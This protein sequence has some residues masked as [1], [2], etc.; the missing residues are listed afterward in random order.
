M[1]GKI[2][3]E[4]ENYFVGDVSQTFQWESIEPLHTGN[5]DDFS[6][7]A[8]PPAITKLLKSDS[9]SGPVE[10]YATV[11]KINDHYQAQKRIIVVTQKYFYNIKLTFFRSYSVKRAIGI[12]CIQGLIRNPHRKE[13]VVKVNS[14][15]P[16]DYRYEGD[17]WEVLTAVLLRLCPTISVWTLSSS[18]DSFVKR[19]S[20]ITASR[21][22]GVLRFEQGSSSKTD[23]SRFSTSSLSIIQSSL[24]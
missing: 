14:N 16:N 22:E 4:C 13:F 3:S 6:P 12:D 21:G 18:L 15:F 8:C 19:K 9:N 23:S 2:G 7:K 11:V 10:F 5:M 1:N 17:C 20:D 24:L